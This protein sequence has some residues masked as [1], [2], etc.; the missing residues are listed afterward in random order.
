MKIIQTEIPDVVVLEPRIF[1]DSRGFF[2][3][4]YNERSFAAMGIAERF[5]QD[6]QSLSKQSVLRGLHFQVEQAQGKL[7]RVVA[8]EVFDV[9][10]DLRRGSA[11]FGKWTGAQLSS[12]NRHTIWIPKGFAHGFYTLSETA[13]VAYKVTD[14]YA[15]QHERTLLWNDPDVA[16]QWPFKGEPIL[17]GKDSAGMT[18]KDLAL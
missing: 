6:N 11:T 13:E 7:V 12:T 18:L 8:G 1:S 15:P 5:V 2:L 4:I 10:V 16:I 3:E 9:A 14:F 17:S